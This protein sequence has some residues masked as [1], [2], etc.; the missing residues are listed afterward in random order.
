[1]SMTTP[2]NSGRTSRYPRHFT[3][4]VL[5]ICG[6][7][8][9]VLAWR[10]YVTNDMPHAIAQLIVSLINFGVVAWIITRAKKGS[11]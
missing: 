10:Y 11:A 6:L 9:F 2:R 1:M 8:A 4:I 3:E 5:V 7:C